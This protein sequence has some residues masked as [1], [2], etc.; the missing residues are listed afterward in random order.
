MFTRESIEK[1]TLAELK[2]QI[3]CR[4][5][6][7]QDRVKSL[8]YLR[9]YLW[10]LRDVVPNVVYVRKNRRNSGVSKPVAPVQTVQVVAPVQ[11][12]QVVTS[13]QT[14]QVVAPVQTIEFFSLTNLS[15]K[16]AEV[17]GFPPG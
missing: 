4:G 10:D 13:V 6:H 3:R 9:K 14:V 2:A 15:A 1:L 7:V 11:T 12:V 8:D 17:F 16:D 5:G